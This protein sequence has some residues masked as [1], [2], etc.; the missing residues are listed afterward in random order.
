[1]SFDVARPLAVGP[2][3]CSAWSGGCDGGERDERQA[4]RGPAL[5]TSPLH[6]SSRSS[7]RHM[8][9]RTSSV[10][11]AALRSRAACAASGSQPGSGSSRA[12]QATPP[13]PDMEKRQRSEVRYKRSAVGVPNVDRPGFRFPRQ[14]STEE[15]V[16]TTTAR[17]RRPVWSRN[18]LS[19][20]SSLSPAGR[21]RER[22]SA[23]QGPWARLSEPLP[24][25]RH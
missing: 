20:C 25:L 6:Q 19:V 13:G 22:A 16:R 14:D 12:P 9:S 3:R 11:S 18:Q 5:V 23:A 21:D 2:S 10:S 17:G 1:M 7:G 24:R 8:T 4:A 15:A